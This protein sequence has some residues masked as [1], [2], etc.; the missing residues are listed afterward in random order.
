MV[1]HG[2]SIPTLIIPM[3]EGDET[4]KCGFEQILWYLITWNPMWWKSYSIN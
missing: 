4:R 2:T 1:G 3:K